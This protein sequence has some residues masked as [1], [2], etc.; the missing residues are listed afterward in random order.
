MCKLSRQNGGWEFKA[1]GI[2]TEGE[3]AD[4]LIEE[5]EELD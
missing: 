3:S 5:I 2:G 1:L 4:D